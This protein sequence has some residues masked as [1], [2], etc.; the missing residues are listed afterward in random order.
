[1]VSVLL[2][3]PEWYKLTLDHR[4]LAH[5]M[6]REDSGSTAVYLGEINGFRTILTHNHNTRRTLFYWGCRC[7][8]NEDGARARFDNGV[9]VVSGG[10]RPHADRLIDYVKAICE[11]RGWPW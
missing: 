10:L 7:F 11:E 3:P 9:S 6:M 4:I 1:M 2:N 8:D 5:P